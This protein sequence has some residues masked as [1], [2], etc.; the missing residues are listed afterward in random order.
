MNQIKNI[1]LLDG[2]VKP[3]DIDK[4][5]GAA[6]LHKRHSSIEFKIV[7]ASPAKITIKISQ[8]KSFTGIYH[9]AKR[10]IEIVHETFDRF[11][12]NQKVIV[13]PIPHKENPIN[14]IDVSW[15]NDRMLKTGTK[16]K[17]I[18]NDTGIDYTQLSGLITGSRNLSQPMKALFWYYFLSKK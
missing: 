1:H 14:R 6:V 7:E 3:G 16:L 2:I 18:A 8:G 13:H 5:E 15:I 17:D 10:L 4:M 9:P 12:T 11:F